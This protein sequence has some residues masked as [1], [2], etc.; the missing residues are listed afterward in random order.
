MIESIAPPQQPYKQ[1]T[2]FGTPCFL[3]SLNNLSL[4]FEDHKKEATNVKSQ[5]QNIKEEKEFMKKLESR[6]GTKKGFPDLGSKGSLY[7]L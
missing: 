3:V 4:F 7:C 6:L 5:M 2:I 1:G